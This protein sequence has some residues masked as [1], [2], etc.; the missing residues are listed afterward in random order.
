[1][2]RILKQAILCLLRQ[3]VMVMSWGLTGL[4]VDEQTIEF[5]VNGFNYKGKVFI[6]SFQG[7]LQ[8][9]LDKGES[10]HMEVEDLVTTLDSLIEN[11]PCYEE[12]LIKWI[13]RKVK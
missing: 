5:H 13:K 2:E 8:I 10:R 9:T 4:R 3:R 12:R 6:K 7:H 1:M 11:G